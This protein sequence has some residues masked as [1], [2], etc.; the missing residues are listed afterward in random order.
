MKEIQIDR[1]FTL[2]FILGIVL[3]VI[4]QSYAPVNVDCPPNL[5]RSGDNGLSIW[6]SQ[7]IT[8]RRA[9]AADSLQSWLKNVNLNDFNI[10]SFLAN[11]SNVPTLA[12]AFSG[13][14]YRAMLNGAG[15]F[16]GIFHIY[17]FE[18]FLY[19]RFRWACCRQ[20]KYDR[21]PSS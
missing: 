19:Y 2:I 11:S 7:Y 9:K 3:Q 16:Q 13:G 8:Q 20:R 10:S 14:G 21:I 12:I 1:L 5:V 6:E 18:F 4:S 15:V 17:L